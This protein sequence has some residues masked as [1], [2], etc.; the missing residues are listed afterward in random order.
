VGKYATIL[1]K[2]ANSTYAEMIKIQDYKVSFTFRATRS[3]RGSCS[4]HRL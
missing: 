1:K 4:L 3:R 2:A